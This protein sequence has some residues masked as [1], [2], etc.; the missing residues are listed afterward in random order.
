MLILIVVVCI[1][2]SYVLMHTH[3]HSYLCLLH[4]IILKNLPVYQCEIILL[5]VIPQGKKKLQRVKSRKLIN[6]RR[7]WHL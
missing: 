4:L 5:K 7:T 3:T 1:Y 2:V 6:A